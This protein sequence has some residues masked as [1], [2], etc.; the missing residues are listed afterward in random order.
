MGD[1]QFTRQLD[2]ARYPEI[3]GTAVRVLWSD[4]WYDGTLSGM[5][6]VNGECLYYDFYHEDDNADVRTFVLYRLTAEQVAYE[7]GW[8]ALEEEAGGVLV[9]NEEGGFEYLPER[10]PGAREAFTARRR[11]EHRRLDL[12]TATV[13]GWFRDRGHPAFV[14]VQVHQGSD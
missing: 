1:Y 5:A 2:L 4:E 6:E 11:Q 14:G 3:P 9:F 7:R 12:R 13:V 10:E 8:R